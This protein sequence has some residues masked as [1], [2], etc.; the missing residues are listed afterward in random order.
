MNS[1][2]NLK[3]RG[4][5]T[6]LRDGWHPD[7]GCSNSTIATRATLTAIMKTLGGQSTPSPGAGPAPE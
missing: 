1:C 5:E 4:S 7:G 2:K 6:G 3:T